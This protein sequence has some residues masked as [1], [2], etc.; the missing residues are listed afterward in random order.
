MNIIFLRPWVKNIVNNLNT[1]TLFLD[2]DGVINKRIPGNYVKNVDEFE[3]ING[4]IEAITIFNRIFKNIFIV[5]NQ[6]G[7]GKNYMTVEDLQLIHDHFI[8][9]LEKERGRIDKIY[10]CSGLAKDNPP[11][12]KPN[13]GMALQAKKDFPDIDFNKSLMIGDT[14]SDMLFAKNAGMKALFHTDDVLFLPK[15]IPFDGVTPSLLSFANL[16]KESVVN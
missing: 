10:F 5:T 12:R 1:W 15:D 8:Q 4:V 2:R 3:L 7:I 6:Q 11:C 13:I 9:S 16:L 14:E